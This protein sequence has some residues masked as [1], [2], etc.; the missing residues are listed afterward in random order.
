MNSV[1]RQ[2]YVNLEIILIDDGS[3]DN[4][5]LISDE[6]AS[7]DPRIKVIHQDNMGVA[8]ARNAGLGLDSGEFIS[9]VDSDDFAAEDMIDTSCVQTQ[10]LFT[11]Y[12]D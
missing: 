2:T 5:G 4:C 11:T 1:V 3:P 9:F 10:S 6:F 7:K 12:S 8:A